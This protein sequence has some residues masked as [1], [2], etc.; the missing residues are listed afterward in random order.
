MKRNRPLFDRTVVV[1]TIVCLIPLI[2]SA[3]VY[4]DLPEQ[5]PIHFNQAGQPDNYASKPFAAFLLPLI[6]AGGNVLFQFILN[7][8]PKRDPNERI[9]RLSRWLIAV[10]ALFFMP[11]S[12]LVALGKPIKVELV[13]PMAVSVIFLIIGNYLPKCKHNYTIGFK[14][15]WTLASEE[16]W[17]KTHRLAGWLWTVGSL[18]M[19]I[20]LF[21]NM[22]AAILFVSVIP[23]ITVGPV[24]YSFILSLKQGPTDNA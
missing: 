13:V 9:Y 21:L 12:L 6:L 17:K 22:N 14:L 2:F 1:T 15:P 3:L 4:K 18:G 8:D 23:I 5:V 7:S 24:L 19:I 10:M 20:C 16:N 11:L